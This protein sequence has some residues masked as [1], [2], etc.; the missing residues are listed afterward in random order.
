MDVEELDVMEGKIVAAV[1][2]SLAV[3][4]AGVSGSSINSDVD[5]VLPEEDSPLNKFT[6]SFDILNRLMAL[7]EPTKEATVTVNLSDQH[8]I[9]VQASKLEVEGLESL[10]GATAVSSGTEIGLTNFNGNIV[11]MK[12]E[13]ELLGS[14]QGFY[15]EELNVTSSTPINQKV[16]TDYILAENVSNSEYSLQASNMK[17]ISQNGSTS[18][19]RS[20]TSVEITAFQGDIEFRPEINQV[21]FEGKVDKVKAGS[22][23]F[24]G[25]D[26]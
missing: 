21:L 25:E 17:V 18:I 2:T 15:T 19:S 11:M 8:D 24:S 22:A 10:E 12:N 3:V 16:Q 26:N 1:F 13:T 6:S 9:N 5:E 14:A 23:T 7:P 20:S 4:F